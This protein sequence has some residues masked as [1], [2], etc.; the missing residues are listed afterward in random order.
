MT[1]LPRADPCG[2]CGKCCQH[3]GLPPFEAANPLF[4]PQPVSTRELSDAQLADAVLDTELLLL[5][6]ADLRHA[7]AE[8]VLGLVAD[9]SGRPCPWY[10]PAANNCRHYDWRP[11]TCRR[12]WAGDDRCV[13]LRTDPHAVMHWQDDTGPAAWQNPRAAVNGPPAG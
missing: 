5:M 2:G 7:H 8:L 6:P 12:F 3:I 1:A 13:E 9:P 10:D 11:A 4:G